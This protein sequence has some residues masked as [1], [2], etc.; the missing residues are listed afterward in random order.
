MT[1]PDARLNGSG[2]VYASGIFKKDHSHDNASPDVVEAAE[3]YIAAG[4]NI[5]PVRLDKTPIGTGWTK[6]AYSRDEVIEALTGGHGGVAIGIVGGKLNH[7]LVPIDFDK[8]EA[9]IWF[10][11]ECAARGY[12]PNDCPV[13]ITPGHE[14]RPDGTRIEGRHRYFTDPSGQLGNGEGQLPDG[15]NVRAA[16]FVLLPPSPHPSGGR[17]RWLRGC[18]LDDHASGSPII[19]DF[20]RDA[21]LARRVPHQLHTVNGAT[22][23]VQPPERTYRY[24]WAALDN[25]RQ[26][27]AQTAPGGRNQALNNAALKLGSLV[28]HGAFTEDEIHATLH[29]ASQLNGLIADDGPGA[30]EATFKSGFTA[31]V[32]QPRDVKQ[33]PL[34]NGQEQ[35]K[36]AKAVGDSAKQADIPKL[37]VV[38]AGHAIRRRI[39]PRQWL[40]GNLFCCN[41]L[42]CLIAHGGVG[43][44]ALRLVQLISI[45]I[46]RS[47]CGDH[48]FRRERVLI[49]CLEDD[50]DE[51]DRRIQAACL[52]HGIDVNGSEL[53]GWLYY[54]VL[55]GVKL[56]E[57]R[58]GSP[59]VGILD[60]MVRQ[61]IA[62]YGIKLISFDPMVK[63]HDLDENN[64][65]NVDYV[66]TLLAKI[67]QDLKVATDVVHHTRKGIAEAGNTDAARGAVAL[68][69][70]G[71]LAY[72]LV[73]MTE[74]E[75]LLYGVNEDER[76]LYIRMDRGKVNLTA[77]NGKTK[78]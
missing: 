32:A 71:R 36:Q 48:V 5:I 18:S 27:V 17:Y 15:I 61:A 42:A 35:S 34:P 47:L 14:F 49:V 16:G 21:I 63:L 66:A 53:D 56:A 6:R 78:W 28:H 25:E 64:N 72:T 1:E 46:G 52:Y 69:D 33:S 30:F 8:L 77:P 26:I 22:S 7:N 58:Q 54:C 43:K 13:A 2:T 67:A 73:R 10:R 57:L 45:A 4:Y 12:D 29:A 9:E 74:D 51:L 68:I 40:L 59:Q 11:Q 37:K 24:C 62:D 20:M 76:E 65:M 50:V 55:P 3:R 38:N 41:Y 70:G 44:T 60:A 23:P 31:G 39:Q 19:L 75:A